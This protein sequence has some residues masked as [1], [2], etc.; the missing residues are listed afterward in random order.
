MAW[1]SDTKKTMKIAIFSLLNL[2]FYEGLRDK[3]LSETK[4]KERKILPMK[5]L[6]FLYV[7]VLTALPTQA[8][9]SLKLST[10]NMEW[11]VSE[12]NKRFAPSLRSNADFY[13]MALYFQTLET[14]ILAFQEVGDSNALTRIIGDQYRVYLS[15]RSQPEYAHLQFDNLNQYT[16]FAIRHDIAVKDVAD[17]SLQ[18]TS[19]RNRL[20]FASYLIVQ[21]EHSQPIHLLSVH[22]KA[23]CTGRFEPK[24][25]CKTLKA[26]GKALNQWIKTREENGEP[27]IISG[28]FNHNLS[29]NGDWLWRDISEDSDAVLASKNVAAKCKVR[30]RNHPNRTHQFRSVIDHMIISQDIKVSSIAQNLYQ[31]QDVLDYQLSDHCP[32]TATFELGQ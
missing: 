4:Q 16:G 23:R 28:D 12:G 24:S 31:T 8:T 29:Y 14:P 1:L 30:S 21:P 11:F 17:F 10:W 5:P 2:I 6:I 3:G 9:E 27:Y 13:K 32:I 20:R 22:L 26:Q 18:P 15:D 25:A 7:V 19:H